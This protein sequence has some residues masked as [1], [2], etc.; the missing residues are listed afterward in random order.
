MSDRRCQNVRPSV[1]NPCLK[2]EESCEIPFIIAPRKEVNN[3]W[4]FNFGGDCDS[5]SSEA[6][7]EASET[8][9]CSLK[10]LCDDGQYDTCPDMRRTCTQEESCDER[11]KS[12]KCPCKK[13]KKKYSSSSTEEKRKVYKGHSSSSSSSSGTE[14][15]RK[16]PK[17]KQAKKVI[18]PAKQ[19]E[20]TTTEKGE[21]KRDEETTVDN[22]GDWK[23]KGD[24]KKKANKAD[25][26]SVSKEST[27]TER[28]ED[29]KAQSVKMFV[30]TLADKAQS[31]NAFRIPEGGKVWAPRINVKRGNCYHFNVSQ[32]AGLGALELYF[33]TD[34]M[35]GGVDFSAPDGPAL[36]GTSSTTNGILSLRIDA[37]TPSCLYYQ[38]KNGSFRG[39][40]IIVHDK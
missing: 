28:I 39:G 5:S 32:N 15:K 17:K 27:S 33:T 9:G 23:K 2:N 16:V 1:R 30:V 11:K 40:M 31:P 20:D 35:G 12:G 36:P 34:I 14:E 24:N 4:K 18:K 10:Y 37:S 6:D 29:N 25:W 26:K 19:Q 8:E 38:A 13:I 7:C 21:W 22:R 3:R